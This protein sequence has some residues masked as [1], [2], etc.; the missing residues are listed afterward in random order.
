MGEG[1]R[2]VQMTRWSMHV[3]EG[4]KQQQGL[5]GRER[6]ITLFIYLFVYE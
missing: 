3:G 2:Y 5:G 6:C 4:N 1:L